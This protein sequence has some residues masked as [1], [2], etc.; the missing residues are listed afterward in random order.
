V[1]SSQDAPG[2]QHRDPFNGSLG[3]ADDAR[4]ENELEGIS[5]RVEAATFLQTRFVVPV[6]KLLTLMKIGA[7]SGGFA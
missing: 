6:V 2:S 4:G 7:V 5:D 3:V 1:T